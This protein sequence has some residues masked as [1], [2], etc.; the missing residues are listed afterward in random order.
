MKTEE[1]ITVK[2]A[3][4]RYNLTE[5]KMTELIKS[6][7]INAWD[8]PRDARSKIVSVSELEAY[9]RTPRECSMRT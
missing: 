6:K 8:N 1:T 9:L 7:I 5:Y 2:E 3:R 4:T